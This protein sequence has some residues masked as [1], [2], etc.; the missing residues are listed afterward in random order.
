MAELTEQNQNIR[1]ADQPTC[2]ALC[3]YNTMN[4]TKVNPNF[5]TTHTYTHPLR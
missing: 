4:K 3:K 5:V 1:L 2:Y